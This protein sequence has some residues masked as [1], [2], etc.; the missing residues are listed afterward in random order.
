ALRLAKEEAEESLQN[1]RMLMAA[2]VESSEDAIIGIT[3]DGIITSW[4]RGAENIFG[5]PAAEIVGQTMSALIPPECCDE[6][7][8]ILYNIRHGETVK[9]LDTVRVC[10]DG[11]QIYVSIS[12]SPILDKEGRIIGASKIARDITDRKLAEASILDLNANLEQKI[13]ERTAELTTANRELDSFAYAVSHDLRAPLRAMSG[14]SQALTEDYGSQLQDEARVYLEQINLAG[15]KMS[16]LI[17]GLLTLSRSTR[18][19]LQQD[20]VDISTLSERLLAELMQNDPGRQ[21]AVQ[22]K[23]GLQAYGD[24][25]MIEVLMRNLLGNAWKYTEHS[26][27]PSIRVY[28]EEQNF[29]RRFCVADNGA[30]F[31]MAHANRLFQPFQRLHRQEEFS[32][33]GIGLATVQ[34]IVNRHGGIIEAFG[35]P[36][37]GAKFCFTLPNMPANIARIINEA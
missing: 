35:E 26:A 32:G 1:E 19:E 25:R 24:T 23:P 9:Q 7:R 28:D 10:K 14:F 22:I 31:D 34:R 11:S 5:Y 8:K 16:E 27:T 15:R 2:I 18:G 6:E 17:D 21:V 37:K 3:L 20:A 36:G 4:N 13:S 12:V 33:I 29:D 30:G